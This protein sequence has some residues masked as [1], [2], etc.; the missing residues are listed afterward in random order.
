MNRSG[1]LA[2]AA[3]QPP[4]RPKRHIG[5]SGRGSVNGSEATPLIAQGSSVTVPLRLGVGAALFGPSDNIGFAIRAPLEI[6]IRMRSAP[7]EFYGEIALA[8]EVIGAPD[9]PRLDVQGGGGFRLY[10]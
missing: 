3:T 9:D 4:L 5:I 8:L 2:P 1:R 6:G 7:L 10:F